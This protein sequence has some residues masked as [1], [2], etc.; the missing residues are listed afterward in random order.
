MCRCVG[1][2]GISSLGCFSKLIFPLSPSINYLSSW[3]QTS[4]NNKHK[5]HAYREECEEDHTKTNMHMSCT[6]QRSH[7]HYNWAQRRDYVQ[8]KTRMHTN[9]DYSRLSLCHSWQELLTEPKASMF[10]CSFAMS[11]TERLFVMAVLGTSGVWQP[12]QG[13]P[14]IHI[15]HW[16]SCTLLHRNFHVHLCSLLICS[17]MIEIK[18]ERISKGIRG[19]YNSFMLINH[20]H[21]L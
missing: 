20:Q 21:N 10:I 12:P 18:S 3:Q 4:N 17:A 19:H 15:F 9:K 6:G 5:I 1:Y 14:C 11:F 16:F 7:Y 13:H 2:I 8:I